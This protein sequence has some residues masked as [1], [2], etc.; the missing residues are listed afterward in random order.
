MAINPFVFFR[1]LIGCLFVIS[2]FGKLIVPYQNFLYVVESYELFAAPLDKIAAITVPWVEF[3][4]GA[5]L[6]LG[7]ELR[8][9]L[10]VFISMTFLFILIVAQAVIRKL[11]LSECGCFG[12]LIAIPPKAMLIM[13]CLLLILLMLL[14]KRLADTQLFSLDRYFENRRIK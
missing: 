12:D 14:A 9:I 11:P 8:W 10:R 6:I 5:F 13:D 3:I 1:I 2:G 7:L 4:C